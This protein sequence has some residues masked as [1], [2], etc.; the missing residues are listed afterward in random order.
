MR[1]PLRHVVVLGALVTVGSGSTGVAHAGW[2]SPATLAAKCKYKDTFRCIV[3]PAP[4]VAI[5][6]KGKGLVA[7]VVGNGRVRA[8]VV[9]SKGRVSRVRTIGS[10]Y[11]PSVALTKQGA[12]V[13]VWSDR[14][15]LR[16][17]RRAVGH[18]FGSSRRLVSRGSKIGDDSPKLAGQ[19]DGSVVIVYENAY[20]DSKG[21]YHVR[22][23]SVVLPRT[24][25][26]T[27]AFVALG[28]GSLAR[29][30]FRTTRD[31]RVAVCC[32]DDPDALP[33]GTPT[34]VAVERRGLV[35]SYAPGS[36][37]STLIAP[38]GKSGKIETV[39]PGARDTALGIVDARLGGE[40]N[41]FG[42]P[43]LLR[44][45]SQGAFGPPLIA[46]VAN[47]KKAFGPVVAIDGSERNVLVYQEKTGVSAFSS[48]APLYAVVGEPGGEFGAR[49]LLD[50]HQARQPAVAPLGSG[51]LAA[52]QT[53]G[54]K[55]RVSREHGGV[56]KGV[57]PPTGLG[58]SIV[59][60]DFNYNRDMA[61]NGSYA[62]LVWTAKDASIRVS[63]GK[64]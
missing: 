5:T 23:R 34:L 31:G 44:A 10:G 21:R 19:S 28:D 46:P 15:E 32:L 39:A 33:P 49:K 9:D 53:T 14:G 2:S 11:R 48:S 51:A 6:S 59:G 64:F 30:G 40:S 38:L 8:G 16:Y 47:E 43:Q 7:W 35:A 54:N 60:E 55:W 42:V 12:G 26:V 18:N 58:P 17:V 25:G 27:G 20:R 56:F 62:L 3:E 37:W 52:W 29:D 22:L 61:A 41:T 4:R 13:V 45:D 57:K 24:R 63:R 1:F 50:S 36:G